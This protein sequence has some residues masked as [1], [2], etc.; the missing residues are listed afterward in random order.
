[1]ATKQEY[2][3]KSA[4]QVSN[5]HCVKWM[6]EEQPVGVL[7]LVHGMVEYI[8]RY[9]GFAE[10]M[11]SKGFVVVGHDHIAHGG[12]VASEEEWGIV[13]VKHPSD[14]MVEDIYTHYKKTKEA[15]PELPYFILGH[16]MGSY[17]TRKCLCVKAKEMEDLDGAIIM[18]TGTEASVTIN[19]GLA[20]INTLSFFRSDKYRS[21]MVRDMTYGAPYKRYDCTGATPDNSWLTKDVEIV[22]KY[23][24]DPKCT[25]VFS[26]GAYR[27]LVEATKYDN[28]M[29][30]IAKMKKNLP[31]LF[32]SGADDPVGNCGKGVQQ[33]YDKFEAAGMQDLSIKL[34]EGDRHEILNE[35]DRE[36]VYGDIYNWIKSKMM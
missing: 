19:M 22:K 11:C 27:G 35:L 21:T 20:M 16:S 3:F 24:S 14:A 9:E 2:Q 32:V 30:N 29:D 25:F 26:L 12:S 36:T 23:Y 5:I 33:A 34:Y 18:G 4:D 13:H 17:M 31:V 10:F 8:E 7:Q 6:P 1:M 28:N 15:Y